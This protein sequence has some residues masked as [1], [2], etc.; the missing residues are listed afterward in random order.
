MQWINKI[1]INI[2]LVF[3]D[4]FKNFYAQFQFKQKKYIVLCGWKPQKKK[5]KKKSII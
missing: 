1:G 4:S 2:S 3:L 5:K